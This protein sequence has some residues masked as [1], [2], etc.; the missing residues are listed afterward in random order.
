M[1]REFI[2]K[3][4]ISDALIERPVGFSIKGKH[5]S[6]YHASLGKIQLITR[7]LDAIGFNSEKIV[8]DIYYFCYIVS[9]QKRDEC[10]R[11]IAYS[12]LP[13][14]ECLDEDKVRTQI[15]SLKGLDEQDIAA[16]LIIILTMDKTEAIMKQFGMD[17]ESERM[18]KAVKAKDGNKGALDFFGKSLWGGLIDAACERYG[19]S[20]DYVLWGISYTNLRL[21]LTDH[22]K[23]IYLTDEER[24]R[25]HISSDKMVI[26]AD[27]IGELENFIKTHSW[28]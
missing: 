13:G 2:N 4:D 22:V 19:W 16:I 14:K 5:F 12:T 11:L 1:K 23:T 18:K 24:K 28:R 26:K 21:L 17:T 9:K 8:S 6:V 20:F 27:N 10:L 7:M 25:V 15:K 3:V